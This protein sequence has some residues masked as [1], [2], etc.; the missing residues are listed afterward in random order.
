MAEYTYEAGAYLKPTFPGTLMLRPQV[1]PSLAESWPDWKIIFELAR[2][3]GY[4]AYFPWKDIEEAIDYELKP[5]GITVRDLREHPEGIQIQGPSFLYQRFGHN[6]IVGKL[7]I[8]ILNRTMFRK[9]PYMYQKYKKMGFMT[10]SKKVEIL[11]ERLGAMGYDALPVYHEPVES[12]LGDPELAKDFPLVLTT[13]AKLPWY[14]H[15]QMRNIPSL[16]RHMPH[17]VAQIHPETATTYGIGEG[18]TVLVESPRGS[19]PCKVKLTEDIHP[20]VVQLYH[21]FETANANLL[22]DN[23][24]YDPITGSV[25]IR[26]SLCRISKA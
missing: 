21:G 11:S 20:Q 12:P 18:N 10:P 6:G 4:G 13:G 15:S 14:V 16:A 5:T 24:A 26:S 23:R 17:N 3:L 8:K 22:T 25:P 1:V 9:Y 7:A 2:K 19:I